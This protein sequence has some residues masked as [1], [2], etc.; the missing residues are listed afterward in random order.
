MYSAAI[1]SS[2]IVADRP[3]L[4]STGR[5]TRPELGEQGEVLHV[6]RA[7]LQHVGVLGDEIDLPR[8]HHLGHHRQSRFGANVGQESKRVAAKPLERVGRRARLEGAATEH[9]RTR[10][11]YGM[12]RLGEHFAILHRTGS[13]YHGDILAAERRV[14]VPASDAHDRPFDREFARRQLVRFEHW[15]HR[16]DARQRAE[17]NLLQ[18]RLIADAADDRADARRA[19]DACACLP[20]R[21]AL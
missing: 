21:C 18:Q 8:V 16:L 11:A 9:R 2:L 4:R 7:D 13:G 3:R 17:R 6:A 10:I 1:N 12:G 15:R 14:C 20:I 19:R 5:R